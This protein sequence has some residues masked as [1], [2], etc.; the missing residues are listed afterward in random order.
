MTNTYNAIT[1]D[2]EVTTTS[3]PNVVNTENALPEISVDEQHE[4]QEALELLRLMKSNEGVADK[5]NK[6]LNRAD[7]ETA[8]AVRGKVIEAL[9]TAVIDAMQR[10]FDSEDEQYIPDS[11]EYVKK[12]GKITI[13]AEVNEDGKLVVATKSPRK[14]QATTK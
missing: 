4:V 12:V 14:K 13:T 10:I 7:A 11:Q 2:Q 1:P 5:I 9:D 6:V 3:T 8:S